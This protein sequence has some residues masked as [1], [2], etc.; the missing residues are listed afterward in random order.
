M[1][2][3]KCIFPCDQ[4]GDIAVGSGVIAGGDGPRSAAWKQKIGREFVLR[5]V[6]WRDKSLEPS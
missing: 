2:V 5:L 1:T 4:V 6:S 3:C